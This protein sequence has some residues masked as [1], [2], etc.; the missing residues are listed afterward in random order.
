LSSTGAS[1]KISNHLCTRH[2][3]F[4]FFGCKTPAQ[5]TGINLNLEGNKTEALMWQAAVYA[6]EITQ[7][8]IVKG[9]GTRANKVQ[10]LNESDFASKSKSNQ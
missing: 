6:K 9:L 1:Y 7:E 2:Q 10:V 8:S 4:D 3:R 5:A